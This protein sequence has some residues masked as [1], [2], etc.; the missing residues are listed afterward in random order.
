M[1]ANNIPN[2]REKIF[3]YG[4]RIVLKMAEKHLG[5]PAINFNDKHSKMLKHFS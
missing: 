1:T 4:F 2:G 3:G 5:C